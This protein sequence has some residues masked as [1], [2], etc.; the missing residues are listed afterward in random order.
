[1]QRAESTGG[2]YGSGRARKCGRVGVGLE[3]RAAGDAT[4]TR[5][6]ESLKDRATSARAWTVAAE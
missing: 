5:T 4:Q 6:I 3:Y 1:M 2:G